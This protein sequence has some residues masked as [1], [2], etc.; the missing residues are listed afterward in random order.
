MAVMVVMIGTIRMGS[1]QTFDAWRRREYIEQS[2]YR[3]STPLHDLP[4]KRD[5]NTVLAFTWAG[6][7]S[8]C[9]KN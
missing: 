1:P 6:G 8:S 7:L 9:K 3:I 5:K 4:R 2:P